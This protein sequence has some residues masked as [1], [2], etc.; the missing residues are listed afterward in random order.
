MIVDCNPLFY[1]CF[2][3]FGVPL[4]INRLPA[5]C[6]PRSRSQ[7]AARV[8]RAGREDIGKTNTVGTIPKAGPYFL[9]KWQVSLQTLLRS[10]RGDT[11][12]YR[13]STDS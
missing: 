3:I 12:K 13:G 5:A 7:C 6:G 1:L 8:A 4:A 10:E 2:L 9:S 11:R